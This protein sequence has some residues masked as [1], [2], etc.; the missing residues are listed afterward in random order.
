MTDRSV[1]K[2]R[3]GS[4]LKPVHGGGAEI[5]ETILRPQS[6][7]PINSNNGILTACRHLREATRFILLA[8]PLV[9]KQVGLPRNSLRYF[10]SRTEFAQ[11]PQYWKTRRSR[12]QEV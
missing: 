3:Y 4:T 6:A 10:L 8:S 12:L 7:V 9:L 1:I 11:G 5:G 2:H